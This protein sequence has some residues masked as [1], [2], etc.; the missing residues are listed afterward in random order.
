MLPT[1]TDNGKNKLLRCIIL[2]FNKLKQNLFRLF[3][4]PYFFV[5]S[6]RYIAP[7]RHGHLDFQ[8][9]QGGRRRASGIIA[10][11]GG[12][13]KNRGAVITSLQLT[14]TE[15]I[16]SATQAFDWSLDNTC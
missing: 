4:V 12:G 3:T 13:E 15:R 14:F 6:F 10:L 11:G 5:R 9:Y 8:M 1:C 2:L 7:Y 16:V